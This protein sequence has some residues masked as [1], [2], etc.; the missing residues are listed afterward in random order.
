MASTFLKPAS[1]GPDIIDGGYDTV[2]GSLTPFFAD[3]V[4]PT[5]NSF[6]SIQNIGTLIISDGFGEGFDILPAGVVLANIG[7]VELITAGN[8]GQ[9]GQRF[10]TEPFA[11]I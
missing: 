4:G 2:F 7:N 6:D 9:Q 3:G 8:A 5:L 10:D 1:F 11:G